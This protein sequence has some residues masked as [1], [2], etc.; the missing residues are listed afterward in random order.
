MKQ[1][2][3]AFRVTA[4][5]AASL[6]LAGPGLAETRLYWGDTHVHT[7]YSIDAFLNGAYD[8][9]P[10]E[11]Y[12]FAKGEPVIHPLHGGRV[13]LDRPLDFLV[14]SDHAMALGAGYSLYNGINQ[15]EQ[16]LIQSVLRWYIRMQLR[17][18]VEGDGSPQAFNDVMSGTGQIDGDP[19]QH[20]GNQRFLK[21][22]AQFGNLDDMGKAVWADIVETADKHNEPGKFTAFIGWEWT[23]SP[24]GVN[25]HRVVLSPMD[26]QTAKQFMPYSSIQSQYPEDLWAWLGDTAEK[27]DTAFIAI[28]HNSNVSKG[29]MFAETTL[30]GEKITPDYARLRAG[31]EPLVEI[32]QM[33]GDSETW[34]SLSPG[35]IFADFEPYAFYLQGGEP[36]EY[37]AYQADFVR[38]ALKTGLKLEQDIGVNPFKVGVVGST[39]THTALSSADEDNFLGKFANDAIPENKFS[40]A[41]FNTTGWGVSAQGYAGVWATDNTREALFAAFKRRETYATTGPRIIL[42]VFG[43]FDLPEGLAQS[44]DMARL[45][46]QS[47]VPMGGD[48]LGSGHDKPV[49]LAIRATKDPSGANLDQVHIV[50]GW[51]DAAGTTHEKVIPV[52]WSDDRPL[53]DNGFP[54]PVGNTV[55]LRTGKLDNA[56]GA[57][58]LTAQWTDP[59]FDPEQRAF[60]YVRVI[61]IPTARHGLYDAVAMGLED[62]DMTGPKTLQER[63]YSSPIWYTP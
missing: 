1:W 62:E 54:A 17:D 20:E 53:A 21:R 22:A 46:Y 59:D 23:S 42:R 13:Q 56:I 52:A 48:L 55:N 4:G 26:S 33:K 32:T 9:G 38:G 51:V 41:A 25:L 11:A 10:D 24:V 36:V 8:A 44:E 12:R 61:E 40:T 47:G 58:E 57:A 45:G 50:K 63:A 27:F 15:E 5:V 19:V 2:L 60:Y 18:I 29:Y 7:K 14:V 3:S 43:G 49:Q 35:D 28:P 31:F 37:I 30:K 39:D 16:G 6:L 34:P